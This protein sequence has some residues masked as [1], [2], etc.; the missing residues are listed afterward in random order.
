MQQL[1]RPSALCAA[2]LV[3]FA[4]IAYAASPQT[5]VVSLDVATP[6]GVAVA[7]LEAKLATHLGN[8]NSAGG[9]ADLVDIASQH[10][11]KDPLPSV[12]L[13]IPEFCMCPSLNEKPSGCP[14]SCAPTDIPTSQ[15]TS[16]PKFEGRSWRQ[17]RC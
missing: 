1:T 10:P 13:V 11:A 3:A 9:Y 16:Y 2:T 5:M 15:P 4:A 7:D 8:L 6:D 14:F 17:C 12:P